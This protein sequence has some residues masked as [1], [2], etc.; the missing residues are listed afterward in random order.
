M[1]KFPI[2]AYKNFSELPLDEFNRFNFSIYLIDFKWNYLFVNDFVKKNLGEQAHNLIGKNM[3]EVFEKLAH[4]SAFL[5]L[6]RNM[7]NRVATN[8]ITTSPLNMQRL[9]I[10]GYALE[11]CYFFSSTILPDKEVLL[12]EIRGV[13]KSRT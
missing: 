9:N 2:S 7:E 6:K 11:D 3:W 13:L 12:N 5:S 4:D 1:Y 8:I 10:I